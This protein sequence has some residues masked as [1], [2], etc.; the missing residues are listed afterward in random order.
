MKKSKQQR[1]VSPF[2]KLI[3]SIAEEIRQLYG[4]ESDKIIK[5]KKVAKFLC[6]YQS[7]SNAEDLNFFNSVWNKLRI[8]PE[9][10][11]FKKDGYKNIIMII[12]TENYIERTT[13]GFRL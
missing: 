9:F 6:S 5:A 1:A 8:Y 10:D 12:E 11:D 13:K 4:M 7:K 2:D 3:F